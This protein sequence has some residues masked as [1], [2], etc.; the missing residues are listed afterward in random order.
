MRLNDIWRKVNKEIGFYTKETFHKVPS[1]AGVYAWFYPLRIVSD[2]P[3]EFIREVNTILNYDSK[4]RDKPE[5]RQ[6]IDFVWR[7]VNLNIDMNYKKPNLGDLIEVWK[8]A[9]QNTDKFD[10]LRSIIMKASIFISPLYVGKTTNLN[11]RCHQHING[12]Y[13]ANNFH[14]R[15]TEFALRNN[16]FAKKVSDLLFVCIKI[17]EESPN[18]SESDNIEGLVEEILKYLSKPA[19][20]LK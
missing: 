12:T 18:D 13:R 6:A 19:Y 5:Q 7:R 4:L 8:N 9:Y 11:V 2:D 1:S 3:Y 17:Y 14:R 15:Y 10:Q 16:V 20:S